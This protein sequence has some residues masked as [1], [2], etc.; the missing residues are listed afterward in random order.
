MTPPSE[1]ASIPDAGTSRIASGACSSAIR[2]T[3][4]SAP[5]RGV[6]LDDRV[7]AARRAR[8]DVLVVVDEH[9]R[10]AVD[11]ERVEQAVEQLAQQRLEVLGTERRDRDRLQQA[12]ALGRRLGMRAR[13]LGAD[14]LLAVALGAMALAQVLHVQDEVGL[15]ALAR[16]RL[17]DADE[18]RD[19]RRAGAGQEALDLVARDPAARELLA[20]V[21]L[22]TA[23]VQRPELVERAPEQRLGLAAERLAERAVD[24]AQAAGGVG[25]R[26]ARRGV[27]ERRPQQLLALGEGAAALVALDEHLDLRAQ[28]DGIQRLEEVVD[29]ARLVAAKDVVRLLAD[30]RDED[31]RHRPRALAGAD[32]LRRLEAVQAGHL[33][34]EQDHREVVL[35]Q[36]AQRLVARPRRHEATFGRGQHRLQREQV[37]VAVVDEQDRGVPHDPDLARVPTARSTSS[38]PISSSASTRALGDGGQGGGRHLGALGAGGVLDDRG[39]AAIDDPRQAGRAVGVRAGQHD[40]H[41]PIAVVVGRRL[42]QHV[43]RGTAEVH[44][45]VDRQRDG[46]GLDEQVVVGRGD[47][48]AA[49][50]EGLLVLRVA[51]LQLAV[52]AEQLA[53]AFRRPRRGGAGR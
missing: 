20:Q 50:A 32:Q 47:E 30:R 38:G 37:L 44:R 42:Q 43:D 1:L 46:S 45:L 33:H 29:G 22:G 13:R 27:L 39:A 36:R 35:Q 16:G 17:R 2:A 24:V 25:A 28:H 8:D 52:A 34:V 7:D 15:R 19:R 6:A 14:Q 5:R 12:Q 40:A 21:V 31:D 49:G 18:H 48:H 10:R 11:V 41:R 26:H 4:P 23:G 53:R 3:T 51:D 9:E